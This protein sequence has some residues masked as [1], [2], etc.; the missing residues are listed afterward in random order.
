MANERTIKNYELPI[1]NDNHADP[2]ETPVESAA[3]QTE[4]IEL[5]A[6]EVEMPAEEIEQQDELVVEEDWEDEEEDS[7]DSEEFEDEMEGP[8]VSEDWEDDSDE[9]SEEE[10]DWEDEEDWE[11]EPVAAPVRQV[12]RPAPQPQKGKINQKKNKKK[13]HIVIPII[14][15]IIL[16]FLVIMVIIGLSEMNGFKSHAKKMKADL[17]SVVYCIKDDDFSG[18]SEAMDEVDNERLYLREKINDPFWSLVAKFPFNI[19]FL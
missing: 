11:E 6:G 10:E 9:W 19:Y 2:A 5:P 15:G 16:L 4:P 1:E 3:Q 8:A 7:I 14:S 12:K 17:K 13:K 18:A